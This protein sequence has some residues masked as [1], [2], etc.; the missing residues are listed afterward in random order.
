MA[1]RHEIDRTAHTTAPADV[2]YA[3]LL[4]RPTW[5]TWSPLD[6]FQHEVDGADGPNSLGAI[7]TFST[8]RKRSRE[9]IVELIPGRRLSYSLLSGLPLHGYRADIDITPDERGCTLR[10]HS[11]FG[12]RPGVGWI[13]RL[14]LGTFIQRMVDGLAAAAATKATSTA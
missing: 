11:T 10:W 3:L 13:Y 6:G 8:G 1:K 9:E 2:V 14:A 5:P 12:A 4:D 7:G